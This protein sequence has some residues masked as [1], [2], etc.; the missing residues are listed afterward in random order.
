MLWGLR[1]LS[2]HLMLPNDALGLEIIV[3]ACCTSFLEILLG[4]K[5]L[6]LHV[7]SPIGFDFIFNF[8]G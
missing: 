5:L 2:S 6:S 7:L 4:L 8:V 1:L 3:A